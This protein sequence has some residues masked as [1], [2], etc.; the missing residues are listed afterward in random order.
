MGGAGGGVGY[1]TA[2]AAPAPT[3]TSAP[4]PAY[5]QAPASA[6][7]PA[8]AAAAAGR[9]PHGP[10]RLTTVRVDSIA[11][12]DTN[13][14]QLHYNCMALS[15]ALSAGGLAVTLLTTSPHL[16]PPPPLGRAAY[17]EQ[18]ALPFVRRRQERL[19]VNHLRPQR[20]MRRMRAAAGG[21]ERGGAGAVR[22]VSEDDQGGGAVQQGGGGHDA[23][24]QLRERGSWGCCWRW[25]VVVVGRGLG[26]V[27]GMHVGAAC[28]CM[29][30]HVCVCLR[31]AVGVAG[32]PC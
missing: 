17:P 7:A 13:G 19:R 30:V 16:P 10:S 4:A 9:V 27:C 29:H 31:A 23:H 8:V 21:G 28:V 2:S 26:C 20:P 6:Q 22:G 14:S 1:P 18:E 15:Q 5:A 3:Y 24:P 12:M 32:R 11:Y 25:G